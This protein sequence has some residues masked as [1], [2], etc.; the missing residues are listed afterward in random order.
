MFSVEAAGS[1]AITYEWQLDGTPLSDGGR[2]SGST[3]SNLTIT[4]LTSADAGTYT[5]LLNSGVDLASTGL[6]VVPGSLVET[7]LLNNPGFE[8]GVYSVAWEDAWSPF[9]GTDLQTTNDLYYNTNV[10]V[11]VFDGDYV[12]RTFASNPDNGL[13]QDNV[14]ATAGATYQAGGHFYVS[15]YDPMIAPANRSL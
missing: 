4:G 11:S 13:Y 3:S 12:C 14:P 15:S 2:I 9:N 1:S 5:V 10:P 7:N 6:K 8:D